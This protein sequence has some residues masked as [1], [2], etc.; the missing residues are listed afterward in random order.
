MT[1]SSLL[2]A[3][4]IVSH[5]PGYY[6]SLANHIQRWLKNENVAARVVTPKEMYSALRNEKLAFLVG[7]GSPSP[8]RCRRS[9]R[10]MRTAASSSCFIPLLRRWRR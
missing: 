7:F 8:P 9:G 6:T 4:T 1:F 10:S 2:L 3:V 5:E